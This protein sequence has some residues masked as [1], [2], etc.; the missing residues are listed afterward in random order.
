MTMRKRAIATLTMMLAIL[1][2]LSGLSFADHAGAPVI[3]GGFEIDGN[4]ADDLISG[5]DWANNNAAQ[6][7]DYYD[8]DAV[9]TIVDD[10]Y[11]GGSKDDNPGGWT[12][13]DQSVP[14]KDDITR[15][16]AK[17]VINGPTQ[18]FLYLAFERLG[19]SGQG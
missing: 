13:V 11:K 10:I 8:G 17:A 5:I 2:N 1:P 4:M 14:G 19:V 15:V 3:I 18:G 7:D 16:Y 6:K 12:F 9:P